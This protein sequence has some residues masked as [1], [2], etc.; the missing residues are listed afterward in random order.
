MGFISFH[1]CGDVRNFGYYG[2]GARG[3]LASR[4]GNTQVGSSTPLADGMI[5]GGSLIRGGRSPADPAYMVV[6]SDGA[7]SCG[8]DPCA[9][10]QRLKSLYPGLIINVIDLSGTANLQCVANA[11]GGRLVQPGGNAGLTDI[12]RQATGQANVPAHCLQGQ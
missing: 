6:V 11:T 7:D 4:V 5:A 8:G 12:V 9:V 10:A 3:S 1:G 2:P